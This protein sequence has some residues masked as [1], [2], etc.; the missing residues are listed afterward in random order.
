MMRYFLYLSM[1]PMCE[2]VS[3]IAKDG[4]YFFIIF[5]SASEST[6]RVWNY[7][8][9]YVFQNYSLDFCILFSV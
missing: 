6:L 7:D 4:D 5:P 9:G 3:R 1:L 8:D 2:L